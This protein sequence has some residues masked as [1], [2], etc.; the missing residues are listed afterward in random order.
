[1]NNSPVIFAVGYSVRSLVEACSR[2][3]LD[4]VAVDHFGDADTRTFAKGRWVQLDLVDERLFSQETLSAI[5]RIV[6]GFQKGDAFVFLLAGG[7]E[8]LG[9]AVEQLRCIGTVLAPTEAQRSKLRDWTFL[10]AAASASCIKFPQT[11]SQWRTLPASGVLADGVLADAGGVGHE[12]NEHNWLWKPIRGAGGLK[13]VRGRKMSETCGDGYWQQYIAGRQLG[14]TCSIH[15]EY[16]LVVGATKSLDANDWPGPS[17][18]IFRGS[19]GP[20]Q[21]TDEVEKQVTD[22]CVHIQQQLGFS[23]LLQ[24]D[25]IQDAEG[26]LW[27]LE[28]NPRW[29]AGMEVM[30]G[31]FE[32]GERTLDFILS[33]CLSNSSSELNI[34]VGHK[35]S[36]NANR[37]F[38]KAV[39]YAE[40]ELHL[41]EQTVREL[42]RQSQANAGGFSW[43][44]DIPHAAQTIEQGH[45]IATVRASLNDPSNTLSDADSCSHLLLLLREH[46]DLLRGLVN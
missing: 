29:T 13:I 32:D 25:F 19:I 26:R 22:I 36:G 33:T 14:I 43:L 7:M 40:H 1:M 46:A 41:T 34:S 2:A 31:F 45:P 5:E 37:T 12:L 23:G 35:P 18:F 11:L 10:Q 16:C 6:A 38:A 28:C 21:L 20:I 44:A 42:Q 30:L 4:C 9:E 3:G 39:V 24:F 17:E 8:N 27:L 15:E